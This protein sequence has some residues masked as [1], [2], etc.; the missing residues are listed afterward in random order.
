M[1]SRLFPITSVSFVLETL[2]LAKTYAAQSSSLKQYLQSV[3]E[4]ILGE[5]TFSVIFD[6]AD[7]VNI[8]V[9]ISVD[10]N[11]H[12]QF[13]LSASTSLLTFHLLAALRTVFTGGK[14]GFWFYDA[15]RGCCW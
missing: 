11:L 6:G 1:R 14:E 9:I 2:L 12:S 5:S 10:G 3:T 15:G 13:P 8:I 4:S 7:V